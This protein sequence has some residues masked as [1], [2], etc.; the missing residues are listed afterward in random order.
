MKFKNKIAVVTGG[1]SGIGKETALIL[2]K[3]GAHVILVGRSKSKLEKTAKE[4]NDK[5]TNERAVPFSADVTEEEEVIGLANFLKETYNHLDILIN[6]AGSSGSTSILELDIEDWDA[7]QKVNVT[8]VFLVSKHLSKLMFNKQE[9]E[10]RAIVNVA[11]LSGH[12]AGAKIPH[13]S[14]AKAGVIHFSKALAAELAPQGIRVNSVSPGFIETPLTE[15]NLTNHSFV[16]AI[17][18]HTALRRVG[19]PIE[20]ANFIRFAASNESSYMT[21]TDLLVDGGWLIT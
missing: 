13:Y 20:V 7:I 8:S 1:G 21:G 19:T 2:A 14:T 16:E 4:I 10:D 9:K 5:F 18:R 17:E 12:K 15:E 6:N 11:S 3:E